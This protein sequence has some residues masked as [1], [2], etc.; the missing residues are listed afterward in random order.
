MKKIFSRYPIF[1][2]VLV[3]LACAEFHYNTATSQVAFPGSIT[4]V[5][6]MS[7][8]AVVL[9]YRLFNAIQDLCVS[10]GLL[11]SR[12][13]CKYDILIPIG[14]IATL[15]GFYWQGKEI[16]GMKG[17]QV[18]QWT[19]AWGQGEWEV[20]F[21]ALLIGIVLLVKILLLLKELTAHSHRGSSEQ[22]IANS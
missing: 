8:I 10:K 13:R 14:I 16:T 18:P 11:A 9:F 20:L 6:V 4:G 22:S 2:I 1:A 5:L 7:I 17:E 15:L 21:I 3:L 12:I 19:F